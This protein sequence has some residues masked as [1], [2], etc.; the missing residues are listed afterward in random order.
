MSIGLGIEFGAVALRAA[1]AFH[2]ISAQ[3][4]AFTPDDF[5]LALL[6][7]DVLTLVRFTVM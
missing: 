1:S 6:R 3:T 7:E 5:R 4:H 2:A